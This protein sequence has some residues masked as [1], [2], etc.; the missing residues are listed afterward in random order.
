MRFD[1][2]IGITG[3]ADTQ[4]SPENTA[5]R[6]GSGALPIFATPNMVALAEQAC[7]N[8]IREQL[9]LGMTTVGTLVNLK[10]LAA[11]PIG[12]HMQAEAQLTQ[13]EGKKLTFRVKVF[14]EKE[15]VGDGVC[16]RFLVEAERFMH[17]VSHKQPAT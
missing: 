8:A 9:P 13:V 6:V 1:S 10:H 7:C 14:D 12:H 17:K 5:V 4:V 11:T 16:E 2:L 15:K 3:H